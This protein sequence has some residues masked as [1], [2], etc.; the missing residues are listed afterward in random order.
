MKFGVEIEAG[1]LEQRAVSD[2]ITR[3]IGVTSRVAHYGAADSPDWKVQGDGSLTVPMGFEIVTP[4]LDTA[5][6]ADLRNLAKV[7]SAITR[8]GATVNASCGLHVHV[9]AR[10]LTLAQ[11]KML[12]KMFLKYEGAFDL[13]VPESR[14]ANRYCSSNIQFVRARGRDTLKAVFAEIDAAPDLHA[15]RGLLCNGRYMKLNLE[16]FWRHG[17]FEFRFHSGTTDPDKI[18]NWVKLLESFYARALRLAGKS[19]VAEAGT[20]P[21]LLKGT[22]TKVREFYLARAAMFSANPTAQP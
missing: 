15:V 14:R 19:I 12:C 8:A 16:S 11:Q 7:A 18:V 10:S 5:N 9:D 13:L 6:R 4:V 20:L 21:K 22:P 3:A 17:S 1:G 2:L